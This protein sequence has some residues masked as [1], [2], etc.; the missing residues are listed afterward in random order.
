MKISP[1]RLTETFLELVKIDGVSRNEKAVKE[2]LCN[3]L[4]DYV[5]T[6]HEDT[7]YDNV[8]GNSGNLFM[9]VRGSEKSAPTIILSAHMDTINPTKGMEPIV[10]DTKIMSDGSTILGADNR[11]GVAIICEVIKSLQDNNERFGNIEIV[12]SICEEIGLLGIKNFDFNQLKGKNAYVLD[13]GNLSVGT[14]INQAPSAVRFTIEV[15]GR[16]AHAGIAPEKGLNAIVIAAKALAR[17]RQGRLNDHCTLNI[18]S[19]HGGTATNIVPD[20]VSMRGE[21]R[22]YYQKEIDT[23]WT[24]VQTVFRDEV[25]SAGGEVFFKTEQDYDTYLIN[26]DRSIIQYA[27]QA[28]SGKLS[29]VPCFGGSDANIFNK[30]GIDAVVISVGN[31]EPHTNEEFVIIDEMISAAQ[32]VYDIILAS[33]DTTV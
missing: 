6:I 19:I 21:I 13:A 22:S 14:I 7:A 31:W 8:D 24:E 26:E 23:I 12:F 17:I 4:K 10:T 29:V 20:N 32:W 16:A 5:L 15:K 28:F 33:R 18:G 3:D 1:Q 9:K 27:K 2:Y 25:V 30:N 11:L